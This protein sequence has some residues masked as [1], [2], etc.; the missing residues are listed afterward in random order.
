MRLR[1]PPFEADPDSGELWR[2]GVLVPLQ[3]LPFRLL[4]LLLERPGEA[5]TREEIADR[6]WG[7]DTFVDAGAGVNT[8]IA[9]LREALG[10]TAASPRYIETLPKRG[11]RFVGRIERE[12]V[13]VVAP[14][15]A[16]EPPSRVRRLRQPRR[17]GLATLAA[18]SLVALLGWSWI[19]TRESPERIAVILFDNETG[20]AAWDRPAQNLTDATVE[21]LTRL[22]GLDVVGNA[23]ILR[24]PRPFRDLEAVQRELAARWVVIGQA[25]RV[26]DAIV[27]RCHLIRTSDQAHVWFESFAVSPEP[28]SEGELLARVASAVAGAVGKAR[29]TTPS[30]SS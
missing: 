4:A 29:L 27:V 23:A 14:G 18:V 28:G 19:A 16:V 5:V 17:V 1:F 20:D 8:A 21:A 15:P 9:K 10:D 25:Q 22:D 2:D 3:D 24:T 7:K 30:A 12:P 6:L 13:V 11:Y 26:D